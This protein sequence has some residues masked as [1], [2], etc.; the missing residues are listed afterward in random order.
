MDQ[1]ALAGVGL[2]EGMSEEELERCARSFESI[3]VLMGD[4]VAQEDDYGYSFF[5]VLDGR[6]RIS[7]DGEAVAELS[8]GDH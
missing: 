7:R 6:V 1:N 2:F 3:R 5:I 4:R 8:A